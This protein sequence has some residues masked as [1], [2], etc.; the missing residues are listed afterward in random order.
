MSFLADQELVG[1]ILSFAGLFLAP[2]CSL[3]TRHYSRSLYFMQFL[4]IVNMLFKPS[5]ATTMTI[6]SYLNYTFLDFI[7]EM[8]SGFCVTGDFACT[9]GKLVTA[10][11]VWLAAVVVFFLLIKIIACKKRNTKFLSFYNWSKG[12]MYWFFGPLV[13]AAVTT[14]IP[15]IETSSFS[16]TNFYSS[17][18]VV[19]AFLGIALVELIAYKVAQKMEENIWRKWI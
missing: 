3:F 12:F 4:Y 10:A 5:T 11:I 18:I 13:Y 16:S 2:F 19:I 15:F 8:T 6:S 9:Y 17:T 14:L 1:R 7:P